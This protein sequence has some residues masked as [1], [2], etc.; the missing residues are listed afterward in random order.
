MVYNMGYNYSLMDYALRD[1]CSNLPFVPA[2]ISPDLRRLHAPGVF[3]GTLIETSGDLLDHL[4]LS[5]SKSELPVSI[6][7]VYNSILMPHGLTIQSMIALLT[8]YADIS[9]DSDSRTAINSDTLAAMESLHTDPLGDNIS[10]RIRREREI[11]CSKVVSSAEKHIIFITENNKIG[12]T[13]H[14]DYVNGIRPG[15]LVV[16]LFGINFPFILRPTGDGHHQMI[17]VARVH[18]IG[19]GHEFLGNQDNCFEVLP[20]DEIQII[21]RN[22]RKAHRKY[23]SDITW[24]DYEHHVMREF[25]IV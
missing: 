6:Q 5:N 16:G 22:N 25:I 13:Y 7:R 1:W 11:I 14:P 9:I 15:D 24:R 4:D 17:N 21:Q 10:K 12:L 19:W 23:A 2:T 18:G 8:Q 20:L 3:I